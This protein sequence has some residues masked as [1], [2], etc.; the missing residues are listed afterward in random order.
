MFGPGWQE[1]FKDENNK[2]QRLA[3]AKQLKPFLVGLN[4]A[5]SDR[6]RQ[7]AS[8]CAQSMAQAIGQI[9]DLVYSAA[10]CDQIILLMSDISVTMTS[11]SLNTRIQAMVRIEKWQKDNSA[12]VILDWGTF[13]VLVFN[14]PQK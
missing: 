3:L 13:K 2:A 14:N 6:N 4:K 11:S 7:A 8:S 9:V 5:I 10:V 12:K 1:A